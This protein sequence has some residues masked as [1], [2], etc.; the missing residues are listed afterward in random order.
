MRLVVCVDRDDDLGRKAGVLG[1]VVGRTAVLEAAQ[2]LGIAD[3]EDSDTNAMYG[4]VRLLDELRSLG[5]EVDVVLLTGS[6]KVGVLSDRRIGEQFDKVLSQIPVE[7]V[8]LISD[9]AEDE[10]VLPVLQSRVKIDGVHRIYVRQ[11]ASLESTYYTVL[12]A[13]KDQKLRNK[14]VLPPAIVLIVISLAAAAGILWWGVIGLGILLGIYLIFWVFDIDEAIIDSIRS[15]SSDIRTGSVAFGFGLLA[16]ALAAIG[17]LLGYNSWNHHPTSAT[18]ERGLAF[19]ASGLIWWLVAGEVWE[20]GRAFRWYI[21]RSRV[22]SSYLIATTS[23]I[24]IGLISYGILQLVS[25]L[26]SFPAQPILIVAALIGVG[27][28]FIISAGVLSQYL[29]TRTGRTAV[30]A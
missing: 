17:I 25:Y 26:E 10:Y 11:S 3:P 14:F 15:A 28:V 20:T 7:G 8:H 6:P 29:R 16:I 23:I 13:L 18:L 27:L 19:P 22:P 4:G 5:E 24:G 30:P 2:K 9:G 12:T 1:P 21:M